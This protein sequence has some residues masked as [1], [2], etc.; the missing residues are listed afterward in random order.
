MQNAG[1]I[2]LARLA[3][4]CIVAY[5]KRFIS[6]KVVMNPRRNGHGLEIHLEPK[7]ACSGTGVKQIHPLARFLENEVEI[8][9]TRGRMLQTVAVAPDGTVS[10]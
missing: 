4:Y 3:R 9:C 6:V 1:D 5:S 8:T 10:C 7:H 2:L